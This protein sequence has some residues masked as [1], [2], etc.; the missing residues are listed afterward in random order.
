[1]K[2]YKRELENPSTKSSVRTT[3]ITVNKTNLF[4]GKKIAD[5][6]QNLFTNTAAML[7]NKNPSVSKPFCSYIS[8]VVKAWN[9]N[10]CQ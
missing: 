5:K 4:Y 8:K 9:L 3:K 1:M 6:F 10:H 7:T 2:R